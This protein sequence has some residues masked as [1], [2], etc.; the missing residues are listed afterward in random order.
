M[1]LFDK[2]LDIRVKFMQMAVDFGV[3]SPKAGIKKENLEGQIG[4]YGNGK[5]A[6][7][8]EKLEKAFMFA[9][10]KEASKS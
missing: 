4:S 10:M 8:R 3:S 1:E 6:E 9:D 7:A 5:M 2:V